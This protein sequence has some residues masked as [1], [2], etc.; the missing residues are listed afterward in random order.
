MGFLWSTSW[1][2]QLSTKVKILTRLL[3]IQKVSF[4]VFSCCLN[5]RAFPP[6][7]TWLIA[8]KRARCPQWPWQVFAILE[9]NMPCACWENSHIWFQEKVSNWTSLNKDWLVPLPR[10]DTWAQLQSKTIYVSLTCCGSRRCPACCR[11]WYAPCWRCRGGSPPHR[12]SSP[13]GR[14]DRRAGRETS[15]AGGKYLYVSKQKPDKRKAFS[16][17]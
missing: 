3:K 5:L 16:Y 6:Q 15:E 13:T 2:H 7:K 17:L 8:D 12:W 1:D 9:L 11:R 4:W 10:S 14:S